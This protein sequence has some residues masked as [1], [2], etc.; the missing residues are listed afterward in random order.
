MRKPSI[1]VRMGAAY[2][3]LRVFLSPTAPLPSINTPAFDE[4]VQGICRV[5]GIKE[6]KGIRK[7][8]NSKRGT[9]K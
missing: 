1:T 7:R 4:M 9:N 2:N 8:R 6:N 3:D 5:L